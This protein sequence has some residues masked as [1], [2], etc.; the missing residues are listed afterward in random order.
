MIVI[1][2][3]QFDNFLSSYI[4]YSEQ[5]NRTHIEKETQHGHQRDHQG[6]ARE[7]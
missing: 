4:I 5:K 2:L 3:L 6:A 7:G 1:L